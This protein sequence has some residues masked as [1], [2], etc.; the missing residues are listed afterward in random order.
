MRLKNI[1]INEA[2]EAPKEIYMLYHKVQHRLPI[3]MSDVESLSERYPKY[4]ENTIYD[5]IPVPVYNNFTL[6]K[7]KAWF[8]YLEHLEWK[9]TNGLNGDTIVEDDYFPSVP[10]SKN[11]P[12]QY[13]LSAGY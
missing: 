11:G 7:W 5:K 12:L 6:M 13:E 1:H 2:L 8:K 4:F 10:K 9:R 3:A